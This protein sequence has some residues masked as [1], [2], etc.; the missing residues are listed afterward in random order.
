MA[1]SM[2]NT[3]YRI[4]REIKELDTDEKFEQRHKRSVPALNK[5]KKWLET[6]APKTAKGGLTRTA[7]DYTLNQWPK[8]INY[9]KHGD[10]NISNVLAENAI[11]PFVVGRKSWLFSDTPAGAKS[12]AMYFSLIETAKANGLEPFDY[13]N[14]VTARIAQ[15]ETVEQ[16]E[17]LLPWNMK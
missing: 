17:E 7:M 11:R 14:H 16:M 6:N 4:E 15:V 12:S 13:M 9:C 2:I 8:L 3:L 5:L 1:L 10:L